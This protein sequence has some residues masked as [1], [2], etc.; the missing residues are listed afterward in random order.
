MLFL[1]MRS[2]DLQVA[3]ALASSVEKESGESAA[4]AAERFA[5]GLFDSWGV[6]DG[7]CGNGVLLFVAFDDRQVLLKRAP[8]I[9]KIFW[10]HL[11][12]SSQE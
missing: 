7:Q 4:N 9:T 6:G 5:N 1:L 3:V 12:Y 10:Q 8:N 11:S 2:L